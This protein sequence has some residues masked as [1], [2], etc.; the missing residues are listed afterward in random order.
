MAPL[1]RDSS[2]YLQSLLELLPEPPPSA[3]ADRK[4]PSRAKY[5]KGTQAGAANMMATGDISCTARVIHEYTEY[6]LYCVMSTQLHAGDATTRHP[7]TNSRQTDRHT[8][9]QT[10]RQTEGQRHLSCVVSFVG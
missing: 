9:R 5:K 3:P 4:A 7:M 2:Q 10:D 6:M 8:D 1:V